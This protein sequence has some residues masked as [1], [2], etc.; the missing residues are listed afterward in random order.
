[1]GK[2]LGMNLKTKKARRLGSGRETV[3]DQ[4]ET[5]KGAGAEPTKSVDNIYMEDVTVKPPHLHNQHANKK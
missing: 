4:E 5:E 1:M 2:A 3:R